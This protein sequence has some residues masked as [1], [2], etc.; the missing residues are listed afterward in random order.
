[1]RILV[2]GLYNYS[3]RRTPSSANCLISSLAM[4]DPLRRK[5]YQREMAESHGLVATNKFMR[6][7]DDVMVKDCDED[8]NALLIL[9]G[10]FAT[11]LTAFLAGSTGWLQ[12]DNTQVTADL[13]LQ[14]S[15]Q[16]ADNSRQN[17]AQLPTFEAATVDVAINVLWFLS[18]VLS[19]ASALFGMIV[20]RWLRE[21][22]AWQ[23]ESLPE[24]ICLRQVRY[25]AFLRWKVPLIVALLPGLLEMALVMFMAGIVIMLWT[26][27]SIL[28]AIISLASA[29][30]LIIAFS[31]VLIPAFFHHCPYRSPA[32]WACVLAWEYFLRFLCRMLWAAG[33]L[34]RAVLKDQLDRH[35]SPHDWKQRDLYFDLG[36]KCGPYSE[37]ETTKLVYLVDAV[38]WTYE[39]RQEDYLLNGLSY[40][41]E[42][43]GMNISIQSRL[44][45]PIYAA[46]T[47]LNASAGKVLESLRSQ[48][49]LHTT[50]DGSLRYTLCLWDTCDVFHPW[51]DDHGST[52]LQVL[53]HFLLTELRRAA[54]ILKSSGESRSSSL[55]DSVAF[56][57]AACF[58]YHVIRVSPGRT[59]ERAYIR[60]LEELY[61]YPSRD[62]D[63]SAQTPNLR[64]VAVEILVKMDAVRYQGCDISAD[65]KLS[66][67]GFHTFK[68]YAAAAAQTYNENPDY[69][70]EEGRHL[71]VTL[72]NLAIQKCS[73]WRVFY[74]N[75]TDLQSLFQCMEEAA[76]TS[77]ERGI[78]NC[79]YY[80]D[81]P[82]VASLSKAATSNAGLHTC[83]PL[84]FLRTLCTGAARGLFTGENLQ[85]QLRALDARCACRDTIS[86]TPSALLA[87][88]SFTTGSSSPKTP[89]SLSPAAQT[90][91]DSTS[92]TPLLAETQDLAEQSVVG[93]PFASSPTSLRS[94]A[95]DDHE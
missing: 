59:L 58:L 27:N 10:L 23:T 44:R 5:S 64:T 92:R 31:V 83:I 61:R 40:L 85:R 6:D 54:V 37:P 74:Y 11:I 69:G 77:L 84:S 1:M 70:D 9:A 52:S 17:I 87:E 53:G 15:A 30:F 35:R 49:T 55:S 3:Q 68:D 28:A 16:L 81:L 21:Y 82:W 13:L 73:S 95:K 71:F 60:F 41:P 4:S 90:P 93:M 38:A 94:F 32:G 66:R 2:D 79:G 51:N 67:T 76:R 18:L 80:A 78:P 8:L 62:E 19:L 26:L 25:K 20:K 7:H 47:I 63:R 89:S 36:G 48:Y 75:H 34:S 50:A 56:V 29:L 42:S 12:Q 14:I 88:K 22:T 39:R 91:C 72:S 86:I 45:I 57:E 33:L 65:S 24:A 43:S 46:C